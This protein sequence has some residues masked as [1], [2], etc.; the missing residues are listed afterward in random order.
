MAQRRNPAREA[1]SRR[2]NSPGEKHATPS[3]VG[4]QALDA[5]KKRAEQLGLIL[6]ARDS[7]KGAAGRKEQDGKR[8]QGR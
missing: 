2:R 3:I 8:R 4:D 1:D 5:L 6:H 7:A